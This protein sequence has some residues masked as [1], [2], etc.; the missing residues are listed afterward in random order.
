MMMPLGDPLTGTCVMSAASAACCRLARFRLPREWAARRLDRDRCWRGDPREAA[1]T[2]RGRNRLPGRRPIGSHPPPPG[3]RS[4]VTLGV[5]PEPGQSIDLICVQRHQS[6][7]ERLQ[8]LD[9]TVVP[10]EVGVVVG[11]HRIAR[12]GADLPPCHGVLEACVEWQEPA[13]DLHDDG[14]R[15][16]CTE[17]CSESPLVLGT[18]AVGHGPAGAPGELGPCHPPVRLEVEQVLLDLASVEAEARRDPLSLRKT[19]QPNPM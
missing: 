8:G 10:T 17:F 6:P 18:A 1:S 12:Q 16:S 9:D 13:V 4:V 19:Q 3:H 2:P 11:G 5:A 15:P 14:A 7:A